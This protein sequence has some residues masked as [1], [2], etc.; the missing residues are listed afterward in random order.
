[1]DIDAYHLC[2]C[3]SGNKIK[4]CCGK[5]VINDL[6]DILKKN[7]G[8]QVQ[9]ALDQLERTADKHG[10]RDCLL[11]IKTHILISANDIEAAKTVN[12]QFREQ[13]P[14]HSMGL[15]H[16]AM[17]NLL[18]GR[19]DDAVNSLQ[20]AMDANKG[21][22]IPVAVS[23]I[24]KV[25]A[26][27]LV[28]HGFLFAGLAHLQFA[29]RLRGDED[30]EIAE[31]F[32]GL[33]QEWSFFS[34]LFQ[35]DLIE[36]VPESVE[37]EKLYS[38]AAR[39]IA[40]GQFRRALQYLT[41]VDNDFDA[42]PT[43]LH[44][45]AVVKTMLAHEDAADAWRTYA[46]WPGLNSAFAAE[47]LAFAYIQDDSWAA[48][49][50]IVLLRYE[51]DDI[52]PV[53]EK[54]IAS[55]I[56]EPV[57]TPKQMPDGTPPPRHGFAVLNKPV[58]KNSESL[59]LD[60]IAVRVSNAEIYG[61]QTDR[62]ARLDVWVS[63]SRV[64]EVKALLDEVGAELGE[65]TSEVVHEASV[66]QDVLLLTQALLPMDLDPAIA[67]RLLMEHRRQRFLNEVLDLQLD[68]NHTLS[69]RDAAK[70]PELRNLVYARLLILVSN[71]KSRF[72]PRGVFEEMLDKLELPPLGPVKPDEFAALTSPLRSRAVDLS[73]ASLEQ[74]QQLE[75]A[76]INCNDANMVACGITEYL[77]REDRD[78]SFDAAKLRTLS[79]CGNGLNETLSLVLQAKQAAD[80]TGNRREAGLA[81]CNE[82]EVQL[83]L[84]DV[85]RARDI[86]Q[87]VGTYSDDEDVKF[88]FTRILSE[89]GL[90]DEAAPLDRM[91]GTA[92]TN[93]PQAPE[94]KLILP[95]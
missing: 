47:A 45:L 69:I 71:S 58:A 1:M 86:V 52:N 72:A 85:E 82:F 50:P 14:A 89:R 35:T 46:N 81:L 67:D 88:E 20:D 73:L 10:S 43:V 49:D 59:S 25:V 36:P 62:P 39:A 37:W 30:R 83:E 51:L 91:A 68:T 7:S 32:M 48:S 63:T 60:D 53:S 41:K 17:I 12:A 31:M 84:R 44:A 94:S 54:L 11:V 40:R 18:E 74:I 64:D 15:Q 28:S 76:G 19:L 92:P 24:F 77:K 21:A 29:S 33:L 26:E 5:D 93:T 65:M 8:G 66:A 56:F 80:A 34:F 38:N 6:N 2:P 79:K 90:L 61:K 95:S 42:H 22:E 13:S 23:N 57:E 55:K 87:E 4:F 9:A 27:A 16:L 3:Q 78:K 70:Q 75:F